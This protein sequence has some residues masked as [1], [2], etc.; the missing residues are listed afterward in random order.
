MIYSRY[1]RFRE[2]CDML[3]ISQVLK[4]VE[5]LW[6]IADITSFGNLVICWRYMYF[7]D[8]HN[9]L[10][11]SGVSD[12]AAQQLLRRGAVEKARD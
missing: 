1:H 4:R 3:E 9:P 7:N 6:Y 2:F 11:G 5:N 10:V 8:L 12:V